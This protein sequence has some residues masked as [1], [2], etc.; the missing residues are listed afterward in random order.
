MAL[1][2]I[3]SQAFTK[4]GLKARVQENLGT[5]IAIDNAELVDVARALRDAADFK[6][7]VGTLNAA[8]S[9]YIILFSYRWNFELIIE[10][11]F[12]AVETLQPV[13]RQ[14]EEVFAYA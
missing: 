7:L 3:V 1:S 11:P 13:V 2:N 6:L 5:P 4:A 9:T 14:M 12:L 10:T 8:K